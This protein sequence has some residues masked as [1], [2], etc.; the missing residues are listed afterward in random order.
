MQSIRGLIHQSFNSW[1]I[2][3]FQSHHSFSRKST[4]CGFTV[5]ASPHSMLSSCITLMIFTGAAQNSSEAEH[6]SGRREPELDRRQ[7]ALE[8]TLVGIVL[9]QV[10]LQ[11][12]F[13]HVEGICIFASQIRVHESCLHEDGIHRDTWLELY[14]VIVT[15]QRIHTLTIKVNISSAVGNEQIVRIMT[16]FTRK[17]LSPYLPTVRSSVWIYKSTGNSTSWAPV[18]TSRI[19]FSLNENFKLKRKPRV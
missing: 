6:P 17:R 1:W 19:T 8:N 15:L 12:I 16:I 5:G 4:S 9:N 18:F 11:I 3:C 14:K 10:V 2:W 13:G 7:G